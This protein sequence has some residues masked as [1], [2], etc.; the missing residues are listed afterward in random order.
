MA[1]S[2]PLLDEEKITK[3]IVHCEERPAPCAINNEKCAIFSNSDTFV[4]KYTQEMFANKL[5]KKKVSDMYNFWC[6]LSLRYADIFF[7][8]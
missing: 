5:F 4:A 8:Q 1:E 2:F 6:I 7:N 3:G